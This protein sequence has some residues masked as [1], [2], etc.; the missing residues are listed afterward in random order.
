MLPK[1]ACLCAGGLDWRRRFSTYKLVIHNIFACLRGKKKYESNESDGICR[2]VSF[3]DPDNTPTPTHCRRN[4][5]NRN[6]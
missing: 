2:S 6:Q 5:F 3:L 4:N 1:D